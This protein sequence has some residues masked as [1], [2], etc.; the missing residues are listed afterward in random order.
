[1]NFDKLI[2]SILK[3][4]LAGFSGRGASWER[5]AGLR[6]QSQEDWERQQAGSNE[7]H[8][9][10]VNGV[11]IENPETKTNIFKNRGD[12]LYH[13]NQYIIKNGLAMKEPPVEKLIQ[14][15]KK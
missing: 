4:N 8:T 2:N 9:A 3:E 10:T 1:M 12:A 14:P 5:N 15:V 13:A 11:A 7:P 6:Q